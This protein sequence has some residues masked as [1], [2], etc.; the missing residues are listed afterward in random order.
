MNAK[1]EELTQ[2]IYAEGVAKAEEEA[3]R[4]ISEARKEADHLLRKSRQ[5]GEAIVE[6]ANKEAEEL[7]R[8][9]ESEIKLSTRQSVNSLKQDITNLIV[10]TISKEETSSLMKNREF[11]EAVILKAVEGF[12]GDNFASPDLEVVLPQ[13]DKKELEAYFKGR[14]K[15]LLDKGITISL[16]EEIQAGFEIGPKDHSYKISFTDETFESFFKNYLRPRSI[17]LLYGE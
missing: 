3:T 14:M 11:I 7:R 16:S 12:A 15:S 13:K 4:I 5:E 8:N 17:K 6:Q 2:K 1:L 9:V 10:T